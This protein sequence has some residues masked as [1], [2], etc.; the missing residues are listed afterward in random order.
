[1]LRAGQVRLGLRHSFFAYEPSSG[2]GLGGP[3]GAP[4]RG[5]SESFKEKEA[6]LRGDGAKEVRS[7]SLHSLLQH[8]LS[9]FTPARVMVQSG[10]ARGRQRPLLN[11]K[12]LA[13]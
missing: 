13:L 5:F 7:E 2:V 6:L 8:H 10:W 12:V 9:P 4:G 3:F 11:T 1:M